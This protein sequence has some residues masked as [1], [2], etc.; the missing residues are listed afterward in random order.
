MLACDPVKLF[1]DNL[2]QLGVV[3]GFVTWSMR[4]CVRPLRSLSD[5]VLCDVIISNVFMLARCECMY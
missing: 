4:T 3:D 5:K 2:T 1:F